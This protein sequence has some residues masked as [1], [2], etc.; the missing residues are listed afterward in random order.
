MFDYDKPQ[1]VDTS[2]YYKYYAA[3]LKEALY[4]KLCDKM[5][6]H[7]EPSERKKLIDW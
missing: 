6:I 7:V 5:N 3:I 1:P 2:F 4:Q